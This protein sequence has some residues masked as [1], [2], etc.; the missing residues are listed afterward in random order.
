MEWIK[1][2]YSRLLIDNHITDISPEFMKKFNPVEYVRMVKTGGFE[3]AMV[4]ACDH[5]GNCYYPTE[6]GHMHQ[7]LGGRDIFGETIELLNRKGI[8]PVAYYTV[9]F[10]NDSVISHPEWQMCD[11]IGQTRN[12]RYRF[13]CPNHPGYVE[14]SKQQLSE[15]AAYDVAGFFIDM[16]FWPLICQCDGCKARYLAETGS[17]IP[18]T[19]NWENPEWIRF[20]RAREDWMGDFARTLTNHLKSIKPEL[21]VT[22]QFSPVLHGWFLGQ[23]TGIVAA[24]DYASGD[25]YG[26]KYQQRLGTKIMS[27]Y[28]RS[29]PYEFMTSRCV[30][31]RDHTSIK[32][33]EE[34]FLHAGTTLANGGA[35]FFIDAINPDGT[36]NESTYQLFSRVVGRLEPFK[37]CIKRHV[38]SIQAD[39]GLYF[40]MTSCINRALNGTE[41]KNVTEGGNN[42]SIRHSDVIAELTGVSLILTKMKIPYRIITDL[43]T[44][45]SGLKTLVIN[46][47]AYLRPEEV[48]Q[49]RSFVRNGGTLIATGRTSL[50]DRDGNSD[51]NFQLSDVFGVSYSGSDTENVSYLAE[52]DC[53]PVLSEN[54]APLVN[55]DTA[56]VRATVLN[57][58]FPANDPDRYAS[59]HSNPPGIQTGCAG[60]TV[61]RYGRGQCIYL[62]SSLLKHQ[63]YSQESFGRKLFAEFILPVVMNASEIPAC[64]EITF[65]KSSTTNALLAGIVN[66]Q[67]ELPNIP[68]LNMA[69]EFKLPE[70]IVPEKMIRAS[71]GSNIDFTR[72]NGT[73]ALT[74]PRLDNIEIIE[75]HLKGD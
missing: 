58:Y 11:A 31:L 35:Y 60:L 62:Y 37:E 1:Q 7:G 54:P 50:Y 23:N 21:T 70:N 66:Y 2:C 17:E 3:S 20:Q 32:S 43:T 67:D 72:R 9:V 29:I 39:C 73:A 22:H 8:V 65:L 14:F 68:V 36:L 64:I 56:E 48:E 74:L 57:P 61:N 59:I 19:I 33:E 49:I 52:P 46:N 41:L 47:A 10:H 69:L 75:I 15:I 34:L 4:Y 44:D 51:G 55:A 28:S 26:G 40:S 5:N 24:S 25:F 18:Q 13:S 30:H 45:F 12:G 27:A 71:D 16:S 6:A 63:Q 53:V 38:P 42:M